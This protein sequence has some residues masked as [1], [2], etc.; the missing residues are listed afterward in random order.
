MCRVFLFQYVLLIGITI[1]STD[2]LLKFYNTRCVFNPDYIDNASCSLKAVRR[3]LT[4]AN[5]DYDLKKPM[6]NVTAKFQMLKFYNQFRPF[7]INSWLN[8]CQLSKKNGI[9]IY[10]FFVK[11][12]Y[13]LA[14]KTTNT[15]RCDHPVSIL[16]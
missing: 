4:L 1:S 9:D 16:E 12:F 11:L 2:Y 8:V 5:L 3:N 14:F 10:N 15:F 6:K 13:R 7:L